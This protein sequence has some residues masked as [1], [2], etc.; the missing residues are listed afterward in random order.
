MKKYSLLMIPLMGLAAF[1]GISLSN[2]DMV[3]AANNE[4]CGA[5]TFRDN[6][7]AKIDVK[8]DENNV[9]ITNNSGLNLTYTFYADGNTENGTSGDFNNGA[10]ATFTIDNGGSVEF[11]L[12]EDMEEPCVSDAG[13][14]I[15]NMQLNVDGLVNNPLY[16]QSVCVNYRNKWGN[17]EI[18]QNAVSYCYSQKV[19]ETYSADVVQGW[20]NTA[21]EL[22]E[23]V[24]SATGGDDITIDNTY[25]EVKDVKNTDKLVCNAFSN[26]NY[27]TMNKY[28]HIE[29]TT[30]N[31][32]EVTC[33][34][35]IEVN[36]SDPVATEAGLC[37]QYLIEIKSKVECDSKYTAPPP[38]RKSVCYPSPVCINGGRGFDAGGPNE[39]FDACVQECDGGE[40]SQKC[41][42]SCY[43]KVYENSGTTKTSSNEEITHDDVKALS[44][45][46]APNDSFYEVQKLANACPGTGDATALYNYMQN[47]PSGHYSGGT[48]VSD[49]GSVA[50][51]NAPICALGPYYFRSLAQT[52]RTIG[53]WNGTVSY[54]RY[55]NHYRPNGNGIMMALHKNNTWCADSCYWS[56]SCGGNTALTEAQAQK[57]YENA[58]QEYIKNKEAC[59]SKEAEC[60]NERTDYKIVVENKDKDDT[61]D[62]KEDW[63]EDFTAH[64]NMNSSTVTDTWAGAD[65]QT[66]ESMVQLV[67]GTCEDGND[68]PWNYHNIITFPGT[69]IN[70][71]TGRPVHSMEPGKEDFYTY[72]GNEYCTKLNS[73]PINTAWYDWK[74]NQNGD[75]SSLTEE[76][77][78]EIVSEIDYN[79][80]G[81]IENYGYFGWDFNIK[82]FYAIGD[83][84]TDDCPPEDPECEEKDDDPDNPPAED[85][86][87]RPVSLDELFPSNDGSNNSR[88]AGFNWTCEATNL[89]NEDYPVQPVALLEQ[90]QSLGDD[91]YSDKYI[92]YE[93]NL[94]SEDMDRIRQYNRDNDND[95]DKPAYEDSNVNAAN[96]NVAGITVYTSP[97][98]TQLKSSGALIQR[99][100][101]G[102]NNQ[103]NTG[104]TPTC[105]GIIED[106]KGC[107]REYNAVSSILQGGSR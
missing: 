7:L 35:E 30:E 11:F 81:S 56:G 67:T 39:D 73:I 28:Y 32:C 50:G 68:D 4:L 59:E 90:I 45:L 105:Q 75:A 57:D 22:Y 15:G 5:E 52:Q 93:I 44:I 29:T 88:T 43:S 9:T 6:Y 104:D 2:A 1:L 78:Q 100:L 77:K 14:A 21:E 3:E 82:C 70:N 76:Q 54:S 25:K 80:K 65:S 53:M 86:R 98:L 103:D 20:I 102:C 99:G 19:Y 47:N 46:P 26:N 72:V 101:I 83:D 13:T 48:W 16:N 89:E 95:Y 49:Y 27:E 94:T 107:M 69:W 64:Q 85:H 31:N 23:A 18:M 41:I 106:T 97:F 8:Y 33:K 71:K 61:K 55:N 62:N 10:S 92:D 87:F 12:K 24:N 37:F 96:N 38:S 60:S 17:N 74:V 42:D 79:I 84:T 34:E 40:Y 63:T 51:E 91:V 66:F 58:V 36:F